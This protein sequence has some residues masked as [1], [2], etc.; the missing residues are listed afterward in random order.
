[1]RL[2]DV[3]YFWRRAE[4]GQPNLPV[5]ANTGGRAAIVF[6]HLI[7]LSTV[8]GIRNRRGRTA[9]RRRLDHGRARKGS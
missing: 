3:R 7:S 6:Y 1:M 4:G 5:A 8:A 2:G 9:N